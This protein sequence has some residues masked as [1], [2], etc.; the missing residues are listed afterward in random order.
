MEVDKDE[1]A[2]AAYVHREDTTE[3]T[4]AANTQEA[5]A[6]S[7]VEDSPYRPERACWAGRGC[8]SLAVSAMGV[9]AAA[10]GASRA[11]GGSS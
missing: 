9:L 1:V 6:H 2:S 4:V 3:G 8:R 10:H 11:S 7:C 5:Y